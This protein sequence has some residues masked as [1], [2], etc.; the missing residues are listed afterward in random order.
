MTERISVRNLIRSGAI[1][2]ADGAMG[3]RL[4]ALGISVEKVPFAH[5]IQPKLV[6]E[7]S[8]SYIRAGAQLV[9]TNTFG[10]ASLPYSAFQFQD[11]AREMIS[12]AIEVAKKAA[13]DHANVAFSC[14]P[15]G[16]KERGTAE[17]QGIYREQF[18][19]TAEFG[20]DA[21]SIE[22]MSSAEEAVLALRAAHEYLPDVFVSVSFAFQIIQ[23]EIRT[24]NGEPFERALDEVAAAM[25]DAVGANCGKSISEMVLIGKQLK[26]RTELPL[27]IRPS[28]GIPIKND[29]GNLIYPESPEIFAPHIQNLVELGVSI[30]GGC[31]GT[32]PDHVQVISQAVSKSGHKTGPRDN[33]G[34]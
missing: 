19:I 15:A 30:L 12:A 7:I 31:C 21:V 32:T 23:G 26:Q 27:V 22:T 11:T 16:L 18:R 3:S 24:L 20:V 1:V 9:Q 17:T 5:L 29:T 8:R 25:P 4:M 13:D 6:E 14:G 10:A 2:V 34:E 28:A 33:R